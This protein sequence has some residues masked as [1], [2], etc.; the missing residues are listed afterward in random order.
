MPKSSRAFYDDDDLDYDDDYGGITSQKYE[1]PKQVAGVGKSKVQN[2][3]VKGSGV[4]KAKGKGVLSTTTPLVGKP[5]P[6]K[7]EVV[8]DFN[9]LTI[10][11]EKRNTASSSAEFQLSGELFPS[12]DYYIN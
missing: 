3:S 11:D 10:G 8:K 2:P 1:K 4:L 5:S 6:N 7:V 12:F 9:S